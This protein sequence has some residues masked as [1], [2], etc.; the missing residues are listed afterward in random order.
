MDSEKRRFQKR[1]FLTLWVLGL[2]IIISGLLMNLAKDG[3]IRGIYLSILYFFAGIILAL[4]TM[5]LGSLVMLSGGV[6]LLIALGIL[7]IGAISNG[8]EK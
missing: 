7:V 5:S 3:I 8:K 4:K 1:F 2:I 6:I